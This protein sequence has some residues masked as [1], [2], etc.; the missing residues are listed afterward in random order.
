MVWSFKQDPKIRGPLEW[1][2]RLQKE[3]DKNKL[4]ECL[5]VRDEHHR[6]IMYHIGLER[7]AETQHIIAS[8]KIDKFHDG[9]SGPTAGGPWWQQWQLRRHFDNHFE[10]KFE[11]ADELLSEMLDVHTELQD[12]VD[13]LICN[14]IPE[15]QE[16][17]HFE[18]GEGHD[19]IDRADAKR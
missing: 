6:K 7:K 1:R 8:T 11:E 18:P 3:S 16:M 17:E 5:M 19:F 10:E 9:I 14:S 4:D 12:E 15:D 2:K 13:R